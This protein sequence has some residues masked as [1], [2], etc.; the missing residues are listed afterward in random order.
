VASQVSAVGSRYQG[1]ADVTRLVREGGSGRY[2][3]A[4]VQTGTGVNAYGGW[5]LVVVAETE[6]APER[7]VA[8][9]DGLLTVERGGEARAVLGGFRAPR[10]ARATL[11]LVTYEGDPPYR[12]ERV[13]LGGK[14]IADELNPNNNF[15]NSTIS[16]GGAYQG[17]RKPGGRNTF[18]FDADVLDVSGAIA[19]GST[20]VDA[21]FG[22]S[23]DAFL[24]GV[25]VLSVSA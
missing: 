9:F 8:V 24:A 19:A 20:T 7:S 3:V 12:G 2:T 18:G 5:V 11:G 16:V 22:S 15:A 13:T 21:V 10:G 25:A 4:D 6:R 17:G 1:F 14:R 23:G